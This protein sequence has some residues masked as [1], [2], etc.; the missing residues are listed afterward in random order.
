MAEHLV[1]FRD[2]EFVLYEHLGVES[3]CQH[4]KYAEFSKE[5]FDMVLD[6]GLV[7]MQYLIK[8]YYHVFS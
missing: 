2:I 5:V 4:E 3:L 7:V 8:L 1:D 6:Q